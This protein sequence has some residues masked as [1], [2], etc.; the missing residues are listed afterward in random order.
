[1]LQDPARGAAAV[2]R[3]LDGL[4]PLAGQ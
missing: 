4:G 3:F 2:A 1:M